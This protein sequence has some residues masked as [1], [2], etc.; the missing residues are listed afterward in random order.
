MY[1][2]LPMMNR[3]ALP[4]GW[5]GEKEGGWGGGVRERRGKAL[6]AGGLE[7]WSLLLDLPRARA[8]KNATGV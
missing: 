1:R 3:P 6:R 7:S 5:E 4:G 2:S 8:P